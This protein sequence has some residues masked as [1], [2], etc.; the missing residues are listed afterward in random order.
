MWE[1]AEGPLHFY[2]KLGYRTIRRTLALSLSD[3]TT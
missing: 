3:R 2:E 1:F